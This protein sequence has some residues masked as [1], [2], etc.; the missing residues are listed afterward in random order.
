ML[1]RGDTPIFQN[2]VAYV[3]EQRQSCQ[4]QIHGEKNLDFEI[5]GQG[6]FLLTCQ[7]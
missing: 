4:T 7:T 5:K 3:K 2:F 1:F 6:H